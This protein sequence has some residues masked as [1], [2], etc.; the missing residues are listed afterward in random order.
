MN[1]NHFGNTL[2]FVRGCYDGSVLEPIRTDIL[3]SGHPSIHPDG[4]H[5]ITD[6]YLNEP[7]A[8][9]DGTVPIRWIDLETAAT[10]ASC[11]FRRAKAFLF[12]TARCAS[13]HIPRGIEVGTPLRSTPPSAEDGMSWLLIYPRRSTRSPRYD[14]PTQKLAETTEQKYLQAHERKDT[15][16]SLEEDRMVSCRPVGV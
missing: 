14:V 13:T 2:R 1:L 5:L 15:L 9:G 10:N 8:F 7:M 3:G 16:P 11:A 12:L 6:T 4:R